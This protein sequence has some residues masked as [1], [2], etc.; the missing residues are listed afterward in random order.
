MERLIIKLYYQDNFK[1]NQIAYRLGYH[2]DTI[3]RKR[4]KAVELLKREMESHGYK[5]EN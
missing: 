4:A 3:R 1:D 5:Q 2:T